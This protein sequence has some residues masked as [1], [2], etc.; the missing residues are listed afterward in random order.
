MSHGFRVDLSGWDISPARPKLLQWVERFFADASWLSDQDLVGWLNEEHTV[1]GMRELIHHNL[2]NWKCIKQRRY[3][4]NW[5]IPL[6]SGD[7]RAAA[8][9]V[10]KPVH[11]ANVKNVRSIL[12]EWR[13]HVADLGARRVKVTK[14]VQAENLECLAIAFHSFRKNSPSVVR[15][16]V[17]E[18]QSKIT[19]LRSHMAELKRLRDEY[20]EVRFYL[21]SLWEKTSV[22][23]WLEI[24]SKKGF[25]RSDRRIFRKYEEDREAGILRELEQQLE[26]ETGWMDKT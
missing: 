15:R 3:Q 7:F 9:R 17:E 20:P 19:L 21:Y 14:K 12:F 8:G 4:K 18:L 10:P 13:N 24:V 26:R 6:S 22:P 11:E 23:E 1:S 16:S 5:I 2:K 25:K